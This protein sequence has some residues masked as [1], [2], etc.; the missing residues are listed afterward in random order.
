FFV[1]GAYGGVNVVLA[2]F[3]PSDL[4]AAGIGWTKSVGRVGTLIAPVLI[5]LGL[6][7]GI[8]ETSIMSMFALPSSLA[9][10]S[11]L[12]IALAARHGGPASGSGASR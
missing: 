2:S 5:G 8:A 10:L 3:Y 4:R 1:L 6:S 7:A 11:L 12:G 9:A